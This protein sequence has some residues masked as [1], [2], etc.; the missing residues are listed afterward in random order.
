MPVYDENWRC[1]VTEDQ[2]FWLVWWLKRNANSYT[3]SSQGLGTVNRLEIEATQNAAIDI[4]IN[5]LALRAVF[6]EEQLCCRVPCLALRC[7]CISTPV[8][9]A[10]SF[11]VLMVS[12]EEGK[13]PLARCVCTIME[14]DQA[15]RGAK[16][17]R[18]MKY[19]DLRR[20][21][22]LPTHGVCSEP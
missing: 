19:S 12:V 11:F 21:S 14:S 8:L 13:I 18:V 16:Q 22:K 7:S 3:A 17:T 20:E 4:E 6:V 9:Q 1:S 2:A 10:S 5:H 15:E